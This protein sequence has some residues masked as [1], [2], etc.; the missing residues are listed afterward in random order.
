MGEYAY[1]VGIWLRKFNS[2][3]SRTGRR[4]LG[5]ARCTRTSSYDLP[6]LIKGAMRG[7]FMARATSEIPV[8]C[9]ALLETASLQVMNPHASHASRDRRSI[10]DSFRRF[11]DAR[12]GSRRLYGIPCHWPGT[13][14]G[15]SRLRLPGASPSS[16][17]N[18]TTLANTACQQGQRLHHDCHLPCAAGP[19]LRSRLKPLGQINDP[20]FHDFHNG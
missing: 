18:A 7:C 17:N 3:Q 10:S 1:S 14:S 4:L 19:R 9:C 20:P 2:N 5:G 8:C 13:I 6:C 12:P 11:A 15:Q 16:A